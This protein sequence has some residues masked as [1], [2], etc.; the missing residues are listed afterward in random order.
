MRDSDD[1]DV[2][3]AVQCARCRRVDCPGC[4][5]SKQAEPHDDPALPWETN[6]GSLH[7]RLWR[8]ALVTSLLP[9]RTFGELSDGRLAPA[10]AFAFLAETVALASLAVVA[11]LCGFLL[12][13]DLWL[14]FAQSPIVVFGGAALVLAAAGLMVGLHALWGVCLELGARSPE[15]SLKLRHGMRFGLYACGWDLLTSPAGVVEGII[16]R[17]PRRAFGPI[18]AA[19]RVPMPAMRAYF[20]LCRKLDPAAQRRAERFNLFVFGGSLVMFA[21]VGVTVVAWFLRVH[22]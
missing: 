20:A 10:F 5:A 8:T 12:A 4:S 14:S 15:G 7:Q 18:A 2:P 17:G 13:P 3:P 6:A 16:S 1:D 21:V 19:T 9:A 22:G 11:A